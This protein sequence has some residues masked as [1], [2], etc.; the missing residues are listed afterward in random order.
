MKDVFSKVEVINRL[1]PKEVLDTIKDPKNLGE[2]IKSHE[3]KGKEDIKDYISYDNKGVYIDLPGMSSYL[4]VSEVT[5]NDVKFE[6]ELPGIK[7]GILY[8]QTLPI[9]GGGSKIRLVGSYEFTY[10]PV[11]LVLRAKYDESDVTEFFNKVVSLIAEYFNR[12]GED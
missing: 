8:V 6:I 3:I 7:K 4:V 9:V 12:E 5:D 10:S 1:S 2:F 11:G